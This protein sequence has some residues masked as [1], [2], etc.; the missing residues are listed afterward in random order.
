M[1]SLGATPPALDA[2]PDA[3]RRTRP[4]ALALHAPACNTANRRQS[5]TSARPQ[6]LPRTTAT[7]P[8][9]P[10][11]SYTA[12]QRHTPARVAWN[13]SPSQ[14]PVPL[15]APYAFTS[16]H[17]HD[18]HGSSPRIQTRSVP[19]HGSKSCQLIY[20]PP[21]PLTWSVPPCLRRTLQL[22]LFLLADYVPERCNQPS[23]TRS[24]FVSP[25]PTAPQPCSFCSSPDVNPVRPRP[26]HRRPQASISPPSQDW[27]ATSSARPIPATSRGL[28]ARRALCTPFAVHSHSH[29]C[30]NTARRR[31][32]RRGCYP[33]V[34]DFLKPCR[35]SAAVIGRLV[36]FLQPVGPCNFSFR[37]CSTRLRLAGLCTRYYSCVVHTRL[38]CRSHPQQAWFRPAYPCH[39]CFDGP[40]TAL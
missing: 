31:P 19:S 14:R 36:F 39:S 29:L 24:P 6:A 37:S 4:A 16:R 22:H 33:M 20:H 1:R 2:P 13:H 40:P 11:T 8:A 15:P 9:T 32:G 18:I 12:G 25:L 27:S 21:A 5:R 17:R 28:R 34:Y 38:W 7:P 35:S 3:T 26:F 10:D 30:D 23:V